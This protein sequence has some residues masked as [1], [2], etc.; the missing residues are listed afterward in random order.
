MAESKRTVTRVPFLAIAVALLQGCLATASQADYRIWFENSTVKVFRDTAPGVAAAVQLTAARNET[1][2][3]Q[4]VVRAGTHPLNNVTVQVSD[5]VQENGACIS[6]DRMTLF[7][8]AYVNLPAHGK[9]YPDAL[10]PLSTLTVPPGQNQPVWI[11]LFVPAEAE[12]G[13]Y[14]GT[15]TVEAEGHDVKTGPIELTVWRFALPETP[16]SR[17]AFGVSEEA[18]AAF[19]GVALGSAAF[20]ALKHKYYELLVAHRAVPYSLP[21]P[22]ESAE[23]ARYLNDPRVTAFCVPYVDDEAALKKLA[24]YLREKG[25]LKKAYFYVVDEPITKDQYDLLRGRAARIHAA[26]PEFKVVVPYFREPAFATESGASGLLTGAC[27]IWCPKVHFYREDFLTARQRLGEE[28]WW[29]VCWEPGAPYAN[30][31][32]DMAGVDHRALFWQQAYYRVQGFLYWNTTYWNPQTGTADP[33]TD[34]ATVKNLSPTVYGDGSLL[35][36]GAK[37]GID[38][39]VASIRL[40]LIRAGL[41]DVEYLRILEEREGWDA[42]RAVAGK[43][44]QGLDTYSRDVSLLLELRETVGRRLSDGHR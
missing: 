22:V 11:D 4:V 42:V 41:E 2:S 6:A 10:P 5:L 3:F 26:D 12:P 43:I 14:R 35:Y 40:K 38:G 28:V 18:I 8:V 44:V 30:L 32:V 7:R 33:W 21:V 19:H 31:Y 17:T 29:Y 39:P 20:Q 37:V 23:A 25:W 36:P 27:D 9:D 15:V 24:A 34:M 1:E 13:V 16:R